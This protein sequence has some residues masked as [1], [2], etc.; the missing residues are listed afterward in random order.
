MG[1]NKKKIAVIRIALS[2]HFRTKNNTIPTTEKSSNT[3]PAGK[4][5][6]FMVA[7]PTNN[8]N[9]QRKR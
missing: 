9:L 5:A 4:N 8:T 3:S 6:A 7:K 2:L 1:C